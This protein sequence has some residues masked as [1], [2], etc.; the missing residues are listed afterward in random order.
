MAYNVEITRLATIDA[1]TELPNRR[2]FLEKCEI[3]RARAQ[4]YGHQLCLLMLDAD[5]FKQINDTYG[6]DAGDEV[7]QS[8]A[9]AFQKI[10]GPNHYAG[11]LGGEE[12]AILTPNT[13][14]M[15]ATLIAERLR[16]EIASKTVLFKGQKITLTVSI[17][18]T[19]VLSGADS[20]SRALHDADMLMYRAKQAGRNCVVN[21]AAGPAAAI[22]M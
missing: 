12:F 6:H 22:V 17:G 9:S 5:R 4:C 1:L 2:G 18:V 14:L 7:L 3:E 15:A 11:R 13:D 21:A 10:L 19:S 16:A 8:I 20:I